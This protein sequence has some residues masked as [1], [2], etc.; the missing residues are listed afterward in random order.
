[1]CADRPHRRL[2]T[3]FTLTQRV[4]VVWTLLGTVAGLLAMAGFAVLYAAGTARPMTDAF[5]VLHATP[6][7]TGVLVAVL[8]VAVT[9]LHEGVH[10]AVIRWYGGDVSFGVGLAHY[11]LPYAYVT[12]T[13][14]LRRDQFVAVA[15]TPFVVITAVGVPV[16]LAL[17]EPLLVYPLTF[18]AA[19]AIG[20]LW[21]A[22]LLVRHPPSVIVEDSATGLRIYAPD[23]GYSV[24]RS[25]PA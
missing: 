6:L 23:T 7:A 11:V 9:V 2:L 21:I 5:A 24:D 8:I 25:Q 15:L 3:E 12:T 22:R 18:N 19:G 13:E 20:D 16:M 4:V 14:H 10:A 17:E 1:M